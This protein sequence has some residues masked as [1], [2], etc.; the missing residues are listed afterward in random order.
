[1]DGSP[2]IRLGEGNAL[3]I[4][5]DRKKVLASLHPTGDQQLVLYPTGPG[6]QKLFPFKTLRT[7]RAAWLP[8]SR[9]FLV[10]AS[11]VGHASRVY[12][13]DAEGGEPKPLTPEGSTLVA[14]VDARRFIARLLDTSYGLCS[15]DGGA[16][17]P[18]AGVTPTD[19]VVG[20]AGEGRV[21]VARNNRAV[22]SK[23]DRVEIATGHGDQWKELSPPDATGIVGLFGFQILPDGSAYAYSY[24]RVLSDLYVADGLR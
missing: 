24:G 15:L 11:E 18:I 21:Y 9:H 3:A 5:P 20:P 19:A 16:P 1:M 17:V 7:R 8:D 13:V 14:V 2:A 4:S 6:E 10:Q 22:P 12:L 23:I